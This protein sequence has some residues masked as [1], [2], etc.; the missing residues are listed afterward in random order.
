MKEQ[1]GAQ[2]PIIKPVALIRE[3]EH[4]NATDTELSKEEEL[5]DAIDTELSEEEEWEDAIDAEVSE[6]EECQDTI[7][8]EMSQGTD[9]VGSPSV[10][11]RL[12]SLG[13]ED[14]PNPRESP[15]F[16]SNVGREASGDAADTLLRAFP[17][18]ADSQLA[19][20]ALLVA[21]E[22]EEHHTPLKYEEAVPPASSA[23][24]EAAR[25]AG[26]ENQAPAPHGPI[27]NGPAQADIAQSMEAEGLDKATRI[28]QGLDEP[29]REIWGQ[30]QS[31]NKVTDDKVKAEGAENLEAG[32]QSS[33]TDA[34][35]LLDSADYIRAEIIKRAWLMIQEPVQELEE[36]WEQE[37]SMDEATAATARAEGPESPPHA[38]HSPSRYPTSAG[39]G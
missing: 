2:A 18:P 16:P 1:L 10:H 32:L 5:E 11:H 38:V 3:Q 20:S 14:N 34:P 31:K 15:S 37:R 39:H 36:E 19:N 6:E 27:G 22:E 28:I 35:L 7:G 30:E 12:S 4:E 24:V 8:T 17:G 33:T 9:A 23:P 25:A 26:A 13:L 21:P 29:S